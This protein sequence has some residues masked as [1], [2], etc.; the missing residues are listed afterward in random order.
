MLDITD[1]QYDLPT[2]FIATKPAEPRDNSRMLIYDTHKD[3]VTCDY[4]YHL[5]RFL[6]KQSFLV[7][8]ET[9]VLPSR[10]TLYKKP[11]GKAK[12]LFL[13]NEQTANPYVMRFFIDRKI[14]IGDK[15]YFNDDEFVE[16]IDQ[17]VHIF[18]V[19]FSFSKARLFEL[20]KEKGTMPIPLYIKNT[21]LKDKELREKYQAIFARYEGSSAAPTASLHF[22]KQVFKKL[23]KKK[24]PHTFVTLHVGMGTF[25]PLT[26]QN[27]TEK[28][29][30]EEWYEISA[31]TAKS[32]DRLKEE[33]K[34]LV[35]VGTTVARTLETYANLKSQMSNV[36]TSPS[37]S[38]GFDGRGKTDLFIYPPYRFQ[39]VDH[40]ITNFHLP[41]SSLMMLV[42][43]FLQ[44]KGVK[45]SLV[46]LYNIA[47]QKDFR[48]YSFGDAMLII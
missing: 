26:K 12:A 40:L 35:A 34:K 22:T 17:D 5:D 15:L 24:I 16:V 10:V 41:G 46:D 32:I 48:F 29:L 39:M 47:M 45:R 19:T 27:F 2:D 25:A 1:Y 30:H 31:K 9:K 23:E 13:V 28:K 44:H 4:F 6:P 11:S 42:Q 38:K 14:R 43:A 3:K 37:E 18:T 7:L 8:N 20:L 36:P 33:G 21:P